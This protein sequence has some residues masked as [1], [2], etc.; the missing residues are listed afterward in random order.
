VDGES[1]RKE[2]AKITSTNR[3]SFLN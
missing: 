2:K 1:E 3:V